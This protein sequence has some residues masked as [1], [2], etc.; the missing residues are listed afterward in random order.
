MIT[1]TQSLKNKRNE[2]TQQ[3]RNSH[4]FKNELVVSKGDGDEEMNEIGGRL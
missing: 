1:S 4:R 3:D 2:Q